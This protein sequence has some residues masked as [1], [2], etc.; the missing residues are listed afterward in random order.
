MKS[1]RIWLLAVLA[2]SGLVALAAESV[3]DSR[4]CATSGIMV[5]SGVTN[6]YDEC[7]A[8]VLKVYSA[9]DDNHRFIAYAVKWKDSEIIVSDPL[10]RSDYKVGDN[11]PFLAMKLSVKDE[12]DALHFTLGRAND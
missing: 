2:V 6:S 9:K 7:Q 1:L 5:D 8:T 12:V 3:K 10:A 11:I 4:P